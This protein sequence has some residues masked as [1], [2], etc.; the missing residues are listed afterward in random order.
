MNQKIRDA[1]FLL[2]CISNVFY[3]A[4][5][6]FYH[7]AFNFVSGF[8]GFA[9]KMVIIPL[10]LGIIYTLYCYIIKKDRDVLVI[11]RKIFVFAGVYLGIFFIS[12]LLGLWQFPFIDQITKGADQFGQ[13]GRV[14]V[15]FSTIGIHLAKETIISILIALRTIKNI[16]FEFIWQFSGIYLIYCWY[17]HD[18]KRLMQ[19]FTMG[20]SAVV[21]LEFFVCGIEAFDMAGNNFAVHILGQITPYFHPVGNMPGGR[22]WWSGQFRGTFTEPSYF[23]IFCAFAL[24]FLWYQVIEHTDKRIKAFYA[25]LSLAMAF[26]IFLTSSRTAI[27]LF[28]AEIVLLFILGLSMRNKRVLAM[29]CMTVVLNLVGLG[30][31][32]FYM[33]HIMS[34]RMREI[35]TVEMAN[36]GK[37]KKVHPQPQIPKSVQGHND[38][39]IKAPARAVPA[40]PKSQAPASEKRAVP[41]QP[42]PQAPASEKRAVE[43]QSTLRGYFERNILSLMDIN[44]RSNRSR[45]TIALTNIRIGL[46][47]P[48]LGVGQGLRQPYIPQYLK[49]QQK[50]EEIN[51]WLNMQKERGILAGAFPNL[52]DY[53]VHFAEGG[54]L[55]LIAFLVIPVILLIRLAKGVVK[56]K[57]FLYGIVLIS[58]IGSMAVGLGDS[59]TIL[60]V[61]WLLLGVGLA[62]TCK[63]NDQDKN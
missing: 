36:K 56:E 30:M 14:Q 25:V 43:E 1:L 61:Y 29:A 16:F 62:I 2:I 10:I 4:P 51:K 11:S 55:G 34:P 17:R 21:V 54:V 20:I 32:N 50:N 26:D 49:G 7:R 44:K 41:A 63:P 22:L 23:G 5:V 33:G 47:H 35:A 24:P 8:S 3:V 45:F 12:L 58:L 48:I 46:D 59:L 39:R 15:I 52:G 18:K 37:P 13:S 57:N 6:L 19:V 53:A 40:Q 27:G 28:L 60:Y 42:K 38:A 9:V 31:G